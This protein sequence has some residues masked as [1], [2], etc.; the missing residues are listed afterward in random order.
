[1]RNL[2]DVI[3][4]IIEVIPD[5]E[6]QLITELNELKES[7]M[8]TAPEA[9]GRKWEILML[10]INYHLQYPPEKDWERKVGNIFANKEIF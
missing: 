6:D 2:P 5:S 7:T 10:V 1:M 3:N 8:F 9:I 4:N